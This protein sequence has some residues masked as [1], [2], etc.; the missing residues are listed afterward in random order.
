MERLLEKL[1][2]L[3]LDKV[4]S[5]APISLEMDPEKLRMLGNDCFAR[6]DYFKA[7][8]C[9]TKSLARS[10]AGSRLRGLAYANRS[11]VLL[12]LGHYKESL[13]DVQTA[14]ANDYP[15]EMVKK[16]HLRMAVCKKMMGM[17]K[18]AEEDF[19][20]AFTDTPKAS[21]EDH[22]P[23]LPVVRVE[24]VDPP[25][26]SYGKSAVDPLISSAL[27]IVKEDGALVAKRNI[28]IGDVLLVEPP[29]VFF[30]SNCCDSF[31][32]SNWIYC[33]ECFKMCLNL[34]PCSSCS[35]DLYCSDKCSKLAW[36]KYHSSYC[37]AKKEVLEKLYELGHTITIPMIALPLFSLISTVGLKNCIISSDKPEQSLTVLFNARKTTTY[38]LPFA[39]IVIGLIADSFQLGGKIKQKFIVFMKRALAGIIARTEYVNHS[40]VAFV[41]N[42]DEMSFGR[43][44]VGWGVYPRTADI[45]NSCKPNVFASFYQKT[46]VLRATRPIEEGE[47]LSKSSFGKFSFCPAGEQKMRKSV[48]VD[49]NCDSC[50]NNMK[51]Y[52][53]LSAHLNRLGF[54]QFQCQHHLQHKVDLAYSLDR[55]HPVSSLTTENYKK[56]VEIFLK[57]GEEKRDGL[58]LKTVEFFEQYF[59]FLSIKLGV[60]K[61]VKR[62]YYMIPH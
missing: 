38:E 46:L 2:A 6:H 53:D 5:W 41:N 34:M 29:L 31:G 40:A 9:F 19:R 10:P 13:A 30:S 44:Q 59:S 22:K 26:L 49:C 16:L 56:C 1:A 12:C 48:T 24:Y 20:K 62:P 8:S 61:Q 11:A 58:D 7:I 47:E 36:D 45:A 17:T 39:Q 14:F 21:I 50:V 25:K 23:A 35:W 37:V 4:T 42:S 55:F 32:E 3:H 15:K 51:L 57:H 18:E 60:G 27:L 52:E 28:E 43:E 54:D 33:S